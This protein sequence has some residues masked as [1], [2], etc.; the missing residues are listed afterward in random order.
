MNDRNVQDDLD[1]SIK[2]TCRYSI[3]SFSRKLRRFMPI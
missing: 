3:L 2:E 1:F